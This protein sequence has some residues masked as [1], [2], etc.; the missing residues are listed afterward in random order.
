MPPPATNRLYSTATAASS[1]R[2]HSDANDIDGN[3]N[4]KPR[5]ENVD[6]ALKDYRAAIT[7][8]SEEEAKLRARQ[9][10]E[11]EKLQMQHIEQTDSLQAK[12]TQGSSSLEEVHAKQLFDMLNSQH[13]TMVLKHRDYA[14]LQMTNQCG[15]R[16]MIEWRK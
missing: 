7:G 14:I 13:S 2:A 9:A 10:A 16:K 8:R 5:M 3:T 1:K 12:Q 11:L 6:Q 4:K 15:A